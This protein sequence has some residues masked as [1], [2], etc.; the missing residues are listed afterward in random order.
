MKPT[1]ARPGYIMRWMKT[2]AESGE[3]YNHLTFHRFTALS[4]KTPSS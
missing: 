2:A 4:K 1:S 3:P